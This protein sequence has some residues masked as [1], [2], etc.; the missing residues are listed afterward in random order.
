LAASPARLPNELWRRVRHA[1]PATLLVGS[2]ALAYS[3]LFS[4]LAILKFDTFNATFGD[5]GLENHILWLLAHGGFPEYDQSG[6]S[7]VYAFNY[8]KPVVLLF[9]PFYAI[10]PQI[11]FLLTVQSFMLGMAAVPLYFFARARLAR[12]WTAAL[13]GVSYLFYFPVASANLFDFHYEA[14]MPMFF[15]LLLLAWAKQWRYGTYVAA[16]LCASINPLPLVTIILFLLYLPLDGWRPAT[17]GL[18]TFRDYLRRLMADEI[19]VGVLVLLFGLLVVY[20]AIGSLPLAGV[21][22]S[23]M[24]LSPTQLVLFDVNAKLYLFLLLFGAL[25][26]LPLFDRMSLVLLLPYVAFAFYSADSA[27][28]QPFGLAYTVLAVGPMYLGVTRALAVRLREREL[29]A[30]ADTAA[31]PAPDGGPRRRRW[32]LDTSDPRV[33]LGA[34]VVV[35]ALV[36]FPLSPVND[37]VSGGY[38]AGN[39]NL[40]GITTETSASRFLDR[41]IALIP[42]NAAVLTQNDIPQVSGREYYQVDAY[43]TTAT[44]YNYILMDSSESYFTNQATI[45]P[46]AEPAVANG[47]FGVVAEGQGALLLE[48]GYNASPE[49]FQPDNQSFNGQT[50]SALTASDIEGTRIVGSVSSY[51]LWFGPYTTLYPGNYTV[52]YYLQSSK[53]VDAPVQLLTIDVTAN[54]GALTLATQNLYESNFTAPNSTTEFVLHFHLTQIMTNVEFRGMSPTGAATMTMEAV[55]LNQ[56]SDG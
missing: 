32:T 42:A 12:P 27:N 48:R 6:F 29:R 18:R 22:V 45:L 13:V 34:V 23:G 43:Y 49:L 9:L 47:S 20:K 52:E 39:H 37:Y 53:A 30:P 10:D 56:T 11:P 4:V 26:F 36:Y 41:V 21:G 35:F 33:V 2:S 55:G 8:Q 5:L 15:F 25:A 24:P 40:A 54:S 44:P 14:F 7:T 1:H 38:F 19:R 50:L 17:R 31:T 3:L 16:L 46:F 51:S 28:W